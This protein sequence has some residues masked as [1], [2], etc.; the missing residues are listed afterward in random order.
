MSTTIAQALDIEA[1]AQEM[2]DAQDHARQVPPFSARVAGFDRAAAYEVARAIH[3][4]R[5]AEGAKPLGRKIGFTNPEVQARY[6][7]HEPMWAHVYDTTAQL[8]QGTRARTEPRRFAQPKLEPEIALHF[9]AAPRPGADAAAILECVDWIAHSFEI[10]Q[11]NFTDWRFESADSVADSGLHGALF[12]GPPV[13]IAQLGADAARVLKAFTLE[14]FRDGRR[15]DAGR[16]SNVLGSPLLAAAHLVATLARQP[17]SQPLQ[18][19]EIVTTGT[20]TDAHPVAAGEVWE[21]RLEGIPLPG[22]T[23]EFR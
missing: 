17:A 11:S 2:K 1:L 9:A 3:R 12:V 10:V 5:V 14:L 6:G 22:L 15:V 18:A 8:L 23:I 4:R 20:I 19:G 21:T 13:A 16:G 7:V